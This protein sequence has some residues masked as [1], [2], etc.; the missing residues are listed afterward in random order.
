M[1]VVPDD[2]MLF[3]FCIDYTIW[4]GKILIICVM[5]VTAT[6]G[7]CIEKLYLHKFGCK[8]FNDNRLDVKF[9][10]LE[11]SKYMRLGGT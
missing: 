6:K 4:P 10:P 2:R 11:C 3:F 5:S 8:I 7:S 9:P 1:E